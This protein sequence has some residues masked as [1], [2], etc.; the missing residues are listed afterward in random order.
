MKPINKIA[1]FLVY[2]KNPNEIYFEFGK[3]GIYVETLKKIKST[4]DRESSRYMYIAR[5][6]TDSEDNIK[7][8]MKN[9]DLKFFR[10]FKTGLV[11]LN[12]KTPIPL[13]F[14]L[15]TAKNLCGIAKGKTIRIKSKDTGIQ[16]AFYEMLKKVNNEFNFGCKFDFDKYDIM[17]GIKPIQIGDKTMLFTYLTGEL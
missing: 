2:A 14:G 4:K 16:N 11:K 7:D 15:S 9:T 5:V 10:S 1:K 3:R 17:F 6:I 12:N 8:F 13:K